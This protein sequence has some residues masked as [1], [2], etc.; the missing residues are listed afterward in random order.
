M[1][2]GYIVYL[3]L[4]N[5]L[6]YSYYI[7]PP[8]ELL[9]QTVASIM[10]HVSTLCA[11]WAGNKMAATLKI[12]RWHVWKSV[13]DY[14]FTSHGSHSWVYSWTSEVLM[15]LESTTDVP[16]RQFTMPGNHLL[17]IYYT[18][19]VCLSVCLYINVCTYVCMYVCTYVCMYVC[20]YVCMHVIYVGTSGFPTH[21]CTYH[22]WQHGP[23]TLL[24]AVILRMGRLQSLI[25]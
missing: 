8:S 20:T 2:R 11:G 16:D 24:I 5:S 15:S 22:V 21:T 7:L 23:F 6:D 19:S 25:C 12:H 17:H 1:M 13:P 10:E 3:L 18:L 4:I 9:E 14:S